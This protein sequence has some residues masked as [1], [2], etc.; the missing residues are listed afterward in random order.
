MVDVVIEATRQLTAVA[1]GP[2]IDEQCHCHLHPLV[3][4]VI[5]DNKS[6]F[7]VEYL[8]KFKSM[9]ENVLSW[10]CGNPDRAV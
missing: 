2:T 5:E 9:F 4:S 6:D 10:G 7:I 3:S 8:G 1:L